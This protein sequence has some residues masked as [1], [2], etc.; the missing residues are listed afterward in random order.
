MRHLTRRDMLV[1]LLA[2][3]AAPVVFLAIQWKNN[4]ERHGQEPV[5]PFR[6]AAN[7]YYVGAND[8]TAFLITGP[9]GNI[10]LDAGYPT[11]APMIMASI[12]KLG[13][14]IKDVKWLLTPEPAPGHAG[15]LSA[16]QQASG[17]SLWANEASA[18]VIASGG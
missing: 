1:L 10:V 7:F 12:A 17:S 5:E 3:A 16:L 14:N 13:F 6:I 18:D 2:L 8:V 9:E 11:T 15:A 4:A